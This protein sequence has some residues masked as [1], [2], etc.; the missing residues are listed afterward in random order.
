MRCGTLALS[1]GRAERGLVYQVGQDLSVRGRPSNAEGVLAVELKVHRRFPP[2]TRSSPLESCMHH[3]ALTEHP[4]VCFDPARYDHRSTVSDPPPIP[5]APYDNHLQLTGHTPLQASQPVLNVIV[6]HKPK[7]QYIHTH[8]PLLTEAP[9]CATAPQERNQESN[10]TDSTQYIPLQ[11]N[12]KAAGNQRRKSTMHPHS[13][14][15]IIHPSIRRLPIF[16]KT[17]YHPWGIVTAQ[18]VNKGTINRGN[19]GNPPKTI[20]IHP[21]SSTQTCLLPFRE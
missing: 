3:L 10:L 2:L 20:L 8:Q 15:S 14:P 7:I 1:T 4:V 13:C 19:T 21:R 11:G 9:I 18:Q 16:P 5:S 6:S 12:R 17:P